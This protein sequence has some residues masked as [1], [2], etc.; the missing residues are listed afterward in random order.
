MKASLKKLQQVVSNA[1][2]IGDAHFLGLSTDS[3]KIE[4]GNLFLAL[5]GETFD[6]HD[7]LNMVASSGAVAVI[8]ERV[9]AGFS[10]PALIVP[11][12]KRALAEIATYWRQQFTL[13]V[14]AVTG[15]NGKTTVKEMIA[16][17]LLAQYG[18][19]HMISTKG[20]LNNEIGVPLTVFRLQAQHQAAVF[21]LGMNH[22]GEIAVLS[23]IAQASVGLV[24]NAQREHQE[25]M[26]TV[27]AVAIENGAVIQS[28]AADGVAVFP[29][30]DTY[31]EI[32]KK[33]AGQRKTLTFGLVNDDSVKADVSGSFIAQDFGSE[34]VMTIQS[35]SITV[36]LAAAGQ[37]NVLNALAAAACCSAI[38]ISATKIAEGLQ[39][40]A[41]V[42]GRLQLKQAA[43]GARLID[44]T[45]N[46]NPD[47]VKAAI[48]V[49]AKAN[50]ETTLVLGDMGEVG[51][52]GAAFHQEIGLHAKAQGIKHLYTFGS[53][54]QA[55]S[56]AFGDGAQHFEEL[57]GLLL[58]LDQHSGGGNT[59][60]IK[61]S[62]FMKM[63]RVVAHLMNIENATA[64]LSTSGTH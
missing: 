37:H 61:G 2:L 22:P 48:D 9:P 14:I 21:E 6:A 49:L 39:A 33:F 8:A 3:R 5:R 53:L 55:S 45:Y 35:E 18:S 58:N 51:A 54:A 52:D 36:Q 15:S 24:N 4:Q 40:F 47:S 26:Q 59:I 63:E 38:G 28:L 10:I 34:I 60:L 31:T 44:D 7:F 41:P 57:T 13:P 64:N 11:D 19:E 29:A 30:H 27:E 17:I 12:T 16:S 43:T 56:I 62:R 46:A 50:A 1:Q 20:N 23:S 32:W 42:S 25:F